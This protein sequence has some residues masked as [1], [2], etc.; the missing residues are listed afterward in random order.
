MDSRLF[1]TVERGII[2][3][4]WALICDSIFRL[5]EWH[6]HIMATGYIMIWII[7]ESM[8]VLYNLVASCQAAGIEMEPSLG[9]H[10]I[11]WNWLLLN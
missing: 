10:I 2:F 3:S 8:T 11:L 4:S 6:H 9:H 1:N 7:S 5:R